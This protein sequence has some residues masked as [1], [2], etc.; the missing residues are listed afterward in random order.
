MTADYED[1][2]WIDESEELADVLRDAL[3]DDFSDASPE[4][5]DDALV[6]VL[7]SMSAA[8]AFNFAKALQQIGK[9]AGQALSDPGVGQ[10]L[11]TSL[12]IAGGAVGTVIGGPVGT[13]LGSNL[14]T[15]AAKALPGGKPVRP[16]APAARPA[17]PVAS[18]VSGG[19]AAAAQGLVL[20]Q[21]PEVLKSLL[22]MAMGQIGQKSVNGVPVAAVMSMLSNVF[23]QAAA[24]A[25]ELM[26]LDEGGMDEE[27]DAF[28]DEARI[29]PGRSLY[30]TLMDAEN[31][32]LAEAE[33]SQ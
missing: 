22:A 31:V 28:L 23:G 29:P 15:V 13:A 8:E 9:G 17:S 12:P 24:D 32:E 20:T 7:D 4:D 19:S 11:R 6:S 33:D 27:G 5:M 18:A 3:S 2:E 10:M 14:G 25:D 16:A 26:Y 21:Q 30:V 1:L